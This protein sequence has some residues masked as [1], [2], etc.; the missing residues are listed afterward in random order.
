MFCL[1]WDP[2][3][4]SACL[5]S[6]LWVHWS[7][8]D[9]PPCGSPA[10]PPALSGGWRHKKIH[11]RPKMIL[12]QESCHLVVA[13][14]SCVHSVNYLYQWHCDRPSAHDSRNDR[15]TVANY[16]YYI[17]KKMFIFW[18]FIVTQHIIH[19]LIPDTV[20]L[21]FCHQLRETENCLFSPK[22]PGSEMNWGWHREASTCCHSH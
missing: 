6:R 17:K 18:M 13:V 12:I 7:A 19:I 22:S 3:A 15:Q 8:S 9:E 14:S 16:L 11:Y 10:A 2:A 20:T 1:L 21:T 4:S 5:R